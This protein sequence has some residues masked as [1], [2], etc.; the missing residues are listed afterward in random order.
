MDI[1]I[2]QLNGLQTSLGFYQ[3]LQALIL[4]SMSLCIVYDILSHV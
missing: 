1:N 2:T 4:L 3:F